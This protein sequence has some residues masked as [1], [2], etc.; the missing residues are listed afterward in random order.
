[1]IIPIIIIIIVIRYQNT[2]IIQSAIQGIDMIYLHQ[3]S[4]QNVI[5]QRGAVSICRHISF[6]FSI[7][8]FFGR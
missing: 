4:I 8:F 3:P 5:V 1:M 6:H 7:S 2:N